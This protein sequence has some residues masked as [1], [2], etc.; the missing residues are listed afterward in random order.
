M[1]HVTTDQ[2][3]IEELRKEV[4]ELEEQAARLSTMRAH[5]HHQID[6]GFET[7]TTRAREREVS[8]ERN[9]LHERIHTLRKLLHE[10]ESA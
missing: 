7:A 4:A 10:R 1:E 9:E 6:F 5:L 2:R 8:D 3:S